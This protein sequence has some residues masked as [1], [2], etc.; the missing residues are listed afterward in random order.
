MSVIA[1]VGGQWGDEGKGKVIDLLAAKADAVVRFSGGDNAGHT[2]INPQGTFKLHLIP[3]GVF[4]PHCTCIIGNGV[5]VNPAIFISERDE[6]QSR[7][8]DTSRV[9][10]SDRAHLV[11]PYHKLIDRRSDDNVVKV[12]ESAPPSS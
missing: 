8:I 2:V 9:F 7:G 11:M 10:I 6:L 5:V 4:Y 1:V 3:S 12:K